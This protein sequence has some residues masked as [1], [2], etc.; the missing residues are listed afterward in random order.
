MKIQIIIIITAAVLASAGM[1]EFGGHAGVMIPTS[2]A[3]DAFALSPMF[4]LNAL[5]HMPLFA[6]EGSVSYAVLQSEGDV[7]DF[8]G[9]LI[10][11]LAG[12]RT[13][14]GPIFYGA[15]GGMY[16]NSFSYNDGTGTE[17]EQ[18]AED[19]GAYG[20]AGMIF[21]TGAM[22]IEGSIKYHLVDFDF[23]EAWFSITAATYF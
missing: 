21:P 3:A 16:M 5:V 14:S 20:T 10:P 19:F 2:D 18:S 11:I 17:H 9:H 12:F 23:S 8:S 1:V 4:G 7:E 15:G 6:I 13:Y 22:D